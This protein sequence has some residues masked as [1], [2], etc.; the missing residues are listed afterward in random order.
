MSDDAFHFAMA[1]P[2]GWRKRPIPGYSGGTV[3]SASGGFP[4]V[5]VDFSAKP[6]PDA[7]E[8]WRGAEP[9]AARS[10]KGYRGLGIRPVEWKGYPT[11][12]DWSFERQQRGQSVRVL[13]R[14]FKVDANRGYAVMITCA[15]DAWPG[16]SARR[17]GRPRCAPSPR[18]ADGPYARTRERARRP[19]GARAEPGRPRS[20]GLGGA[21]GGKPLGPVS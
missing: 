1:L 10:I 21:A 4:R 16:G 5:Q 3:Y 2:E 13:N 20:S 15:K 7:A 9:G 12:A 14:G 17:C 11:V 18:A 8:A 6:L 19:C